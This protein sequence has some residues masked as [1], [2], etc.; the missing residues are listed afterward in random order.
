MQDKHSNDFD[1]QL[2]S[3]LE[4]AEVR[5][6]RR[7][8]KGVS[9]RLDAP[10][11]PA[12]S[13]WAWMKW[14][15]MSLAA[16]AAIAAGVFFSGTRTSIPTIIHNQEQASLLAQAGEAAGDPVQS[17]VPA[18][19][20][21]KDA[22]VQTAARPAHRSAAVRR[23]SGQPAGREETAAVQPDAPVVSDPAGLPQEE[24]RSAADT[25]SVTQDAGAAQFAVR[26]SDAAD[27]FAEPT[28]RESFRPRVALYAQG[29]IGS[30]EADFRPAPAAWMAPGAD[31][32]FSELSNSTYSVPFTIGLGARFYLLPRFSVATGL[33]YS[34]LTRSFT[35][36]YNG[37]SGTI[38]HTLQYIGV[39][40][41]FFYDIVSSD[42]IKFYVYAGGAGEY[43]ISNKYKLFANPD[44]IRTYPVER[45]QFSVG[46]GLGVEFRMTS[47]MGIY[48]DPGLNYYFNCNQPK[49][50]R[51]EKPLLLNFDAGL[52]FN[53]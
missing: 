10:S 18:A 1:L 41:N 7:V 51:T 30:N 2:R 21:V 6:S 48:L 17:E 49:S 32:G 8:W 20:P 34:F 4:D 44:I 46:G 53:F 12:A 38:S 22:A 31:T 9:A 25:R 3:I 13:P 16:A 40:V 19:V 15:G 11:A 35:G 29:A 14:A 26:E 23:S 42:R 47:R 36:S 52:R 24:R 27:P 5:P 33:D 39:P 43:C 50:I 37:Q 45:L 28:V